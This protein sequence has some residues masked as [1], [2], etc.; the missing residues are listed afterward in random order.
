MSFAAKTV[1]PISRQQ[2]KTRAVGSIPCTLDG[3]DVKVAYKEFSTGTLGWH[4]NTKMDVEVD[5]VTCSCQVQIN[6]MIVN[7]KELPPL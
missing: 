5:G 7:S 1:C 3:Q 6:V 4:A 2:F